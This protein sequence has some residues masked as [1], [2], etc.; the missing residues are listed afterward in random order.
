MRTRDGV[1]TNHPPAPRRDIAGV[2]GKHSAIG[3]PVPTR[4]RFLHLLQQTENCR[5][6]LRFEW[7]FGSRVVADGRHRWPAER[8]YRSAP[9]CRGMDVRHMACGLIG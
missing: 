6:G 5:S 2:F 7:P 1:A 8:K 4:P 9:G 3:L